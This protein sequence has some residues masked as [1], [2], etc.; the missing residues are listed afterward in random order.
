MHSRRTHGSL[1]PERVSQAGAGALLLIVAVV[2]LWLTFWAAGWWH[3]FGGLLVA[4]VGAVVLV[5][6]FAALAPPRTRR[7][8]AAEAQRAQPATATTAVVLLELA[9][10]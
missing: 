1:S 9:Q 5:R 3:R 2:E 7:D 10:L 8:R 4:A 6:A